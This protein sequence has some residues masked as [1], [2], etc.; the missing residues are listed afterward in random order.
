MK[1]IKTKILISMLF[2]VLIGS[3]LIG[4]IS[5]YMNAT[6]IDSLLESTIGPATKMAANAVEWKMENYWLPLKEAAALDIFRDSS[7]DD[8][9][10]TKITADIAA[11]NNFLYV[12]KM[13]PS[14]NA[15]TGANYSDADYF[16]KCK[17]T[18]EPYISDIMN[19]GSQMI[20]LLEVPIVKNGSFDG[21]VYGA[22]DADFLT[23]IVINLRMG[24]NGVAYVLD[25]HGNVIGHKDQTYVESGSNMI[26]L[27]KSGASVADIAEVHEHMLRGETGFGTYKFAQDTKLFGYAPIGGQQNWSIGIEVSKSDFKSPLKKSIMMTFLV[28]KIVIL[29]SLVITFT[30]ARSLSKP[31]KACV[32]RLYLLSYGDLNNPV[33]HFRSKDETAKLLDSLDFTVTELADLVNDVS[34]HLGLMAKGDF[35]KEVSREYFGDFVTIKKSIEEIYSS[36]N[37]T[38]TRISKSANVVS[39]NAKQMAD[40]AQLLSQGATQQAASV[41]ELAATISSISAHVQ[42][43]AEAA[44]NANTNAKQAGTDM[45][46]SYIKMQEL[47]EAIQGIN[48]ASDKISVIIK[49]IDDISFQTNILALNASVEAARAGS[50]GKGFAVVAEEVRS[51]AA[52]SADAS[53]NTIHLIE[54]SRNAVN[55]GMKLVNETAAA[56]DRTV[57]GVSDVVTML[58]QISSAT[59][60]QAESILQVSQSV[61]Q[62]SEVIHMTSATTQESAA[63]AADLSKQSQIMQSL[64]NRFHLKN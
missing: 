58:D 38:L 9:A 29:I 2:V 22:V 8:A 34:Y 51:L 64:V 56:M 63:T 1:S 27:A 47:V 3:M 28:V 4:A 30:L 60:Q 5:A 55:K 42:S 41:E 26:E 43:N 19:D 35:Q 17:E 18:L 45:Q 36:L 37:E 21:I 25:S 62:I 40:S 13:D 61:D 14:G 54:E 44:Q 49:T 31:I 53:Q 59:N 15:S 32:K 10:L 50:A 7:P 11:R 23:D 20:F 6:G 48:A 33:P 52:K 46:E 39:S 57:K 24:E 16:Q 12:G